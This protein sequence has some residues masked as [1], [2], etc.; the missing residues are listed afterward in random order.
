[1]EKCEF[2]EEDFISALNA[3]LSHFPKRNLRIDRIS[4]A[5]ET[6]KGYDGT[7]KLKRLIYLQFKRSDYYS[8]NGKS[9]VENGRKKLGFSIGGGF[10]SFKLFKKGNGPH[11]YNQHNLLW[12]IGQHNDAFYCAPLFYRKKDLS[13]FNFTFFSS[14]PKR[15]KLT[16]Q[17]TGLIMPFCFSPSFI[18]KNTIFIK[19]HRKI[20]DTQSHHY[21]FDKSRNIA[22][23]SETEKGIIGIIFYQY[24]AVI[25]EIKETIKSDNK[26]IDFKRIYYSLNE[27]SNNFNEDIT[28]ELCNY[29]N[30]LYET[31]YSSNDFSKLIIKMDNMELGAIIEYYLKDNYNIFQ[32]GIFIE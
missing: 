18:I 22:F 2:I 5:E 12:N 21:S 19:P 31:D 13:K 25:S 4:Q 27:Y 9:V 6:K 15:E 20:K 24:I 29:Y 16:I 10:F 14:L 26:D 3:V 7:L 30:S 17:G 1:M 8:G 28:S 23:H 32:Y 11:C